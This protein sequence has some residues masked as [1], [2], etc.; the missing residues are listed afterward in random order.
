MKKS[1]SRKKKKCQT[2]PKYWNFDAEKRRREGRRA[3]TNCQQESTDLARVGNGSVYTNE[4]T[5]IEERLARQRRFQEGAPRL[6]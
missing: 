3:E 4:N 5:W 1:F 2:E 6:L